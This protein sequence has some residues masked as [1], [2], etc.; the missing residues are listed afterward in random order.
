MKII[1]L[2]LSLC[3]SIHFGYTQNLV[4]NPGFE[5]TV[6]CP[7]NLI[8]NN[9]NSFINWR[10]PT[11][12]GSPNAFHNCNNTVF[13]TPNNLFGYESPYSGFGYA[14]FYTYVSGPIPNMREYVQGKLEDTLILNISYYVRFFVSLGDTASYATHNIGIYF[15]LDTFTID[16]FLN[17][18]SIPHI[19]NDSSNPLN[20]KNAWTKIEGIYTAKG[21]ETHITIGNFRPDSTSEIIFIG[22]GSP[23]GYYY[24]DDVLVTPCVNDTNISRTICPGDSI[25]IAGIYYKTPGTYYDTTTNSMGCDSLLTI[26]ITLDTGSTTIIDTAICM[27]DSINLFGTYRNVQDTFYDTLANQ[28]G[29][30][31]IIRVNLTLNPVYSLNIDTFIYEGQSYYAG[32]AWQTDS[33]TYTDNLFSVMGC[34]S[35]VITELSIIPLEDDSIII[36][37]T[38][39][40]NGDGV[41]ESFYIKNITKHPDNK[42]TIFNR[43]GSVVWEKTGYMNEWSGTG[44]DNE[45]LA[46]GVYYYVLV[47]DG[48]LSKGYVLVI[49]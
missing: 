3:F 43:W 29:N 37:N 45:K 11:I 42:L 49:K 34:D 16:S 4:L 28:C 31:S 17:I 9:L 2:I 8:E 18:D 7:P 14:G 40:P 19:E 35:I 25:Q 36:Y 22:G 44:V 6:M 21:N 38:F 48:V 26:N 33:G 1:T 13:S 24:I 46:T 5:D 20:S 15:S 32:G 30:D 10:S 39:T 47:V 27:G 23:G 12:L 41:N